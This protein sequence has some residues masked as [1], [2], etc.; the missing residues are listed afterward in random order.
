MA[1]VLGIDAAW[2]TNKPSGVALIRTNPGD[3]RW[4]YVAVAPSYDAF[5]EAALGHDVQWDERP[6]AGSQSRRNC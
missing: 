6:K 4:E 1:S 2:T 5:I 3:G